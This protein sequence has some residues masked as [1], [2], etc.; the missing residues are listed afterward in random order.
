MKNKKN[1]GISLIVL[2]TII[3]VIILAGIVILNLNQSNTTDKAKEAVFK[4][5]VANFKADLEMYNINELGKTMADY[6]ARLLEGDKATLTYNSEAI[7]QKT[8]VDAIPL[9]NQKLQYTEKFIIF[10]GKISICRK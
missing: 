6:D 3:V 5:D 10:E 4:S 9:M 7:P 8:M 1:K 2:I